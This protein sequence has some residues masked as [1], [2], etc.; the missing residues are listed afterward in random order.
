M[1]TPIANEGAGLQAA[2]LRFVGVLRRLGLAPGTGQALDALRALSLVDLSRRDD[3]YAAARAVLLDAHAHEQVFAAAFDRFWSGLPQII[4]EYGAAL[5][6]YAAPETGRPREGAGHN[7]NRATA[8]GGSA[9]LLAGE[10]GEGGEGD[11]TGD[12]GAE[13]EDGEGQAVAYSATEA[14]R[15]KDFADLT[16][17]ESA[18][19]RRLLAGLSFTPPSRRLRRSKSAR[20][21]ALLD[22]RRAVRRNLRYGG[23]VLV[24]PR[25]RRKREIRPL[26]L[27][28][29]ISGSMDRY[30]R[31]LLR[32]LHATTQGLEGVETFVFGTRLTRI[33][34]QLRTRD[35]DRA[36][37]EV[38]RDVL[39]FSG[40]T[41]I[42]EALSTFNRRWA[43]RAL[44]RGAIAVVISDG[45]DRGDPAL[46]AAEMAH[47]QRSCHLLVWLNPLLGL[48]GYQPLT[49]GMSAALP[50]IDLFL[51]AHN[52]SSLEALA[53][54]LGRLSDERPARRAPR[55]LTRAV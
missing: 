1:N 18:E 25:R 31:L 20:N 43:R 3:V 22:P 13:A 39:D 55:P 4:E 33:T 15:R 49:R 23:E 42:G 21:G 2:V 54:Q 7:A 9:V 11:N 52:L 30:T 8:R 24:L 35:P 45:W 50:Y 37:D 5:A 51:P 16:P 41:R 10:G 27:I 17:A 46:L 40:G 19:L 44:G 47:L 32:F 34:H 38:G 36:L 29:D 48:D 6:E 14:L 28:C 53:A 12:E 26:A